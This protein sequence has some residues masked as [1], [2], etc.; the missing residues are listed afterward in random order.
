MDLKQ[1]I[2]KYS[3][4][5]GIDLIGFTSAE[6]FEELRE[7][8]EHRKN[9]GLLSSFEEEEIKKRIDPA[10]TMKKAKSIIAVGQSYYY[11]EEDN[12]HKYYG[13]LARTA[14]GKDYHI[15][16]HE[17]LEALAGYIKTI[18]KTFQYMSF[19]DTGP[20]VD[21][22]VAYRAGLGWYGFNTTLINETYGSWF[23]I[24]YMLTNLQIEPDKPVD[25]K[26]KG[27]NLC[28]ENCPGGAILKPYTI[29]PH[30][31]ISNIL[32]GK[33]DIPP[34]KR[35]ILE[36]RIYGCDECQLI[37]P[38]NKTAKPMTGKD[39]IPNELDSKLDLIKLLFI[40][41]KEFKEKF[42]ANAS[43]WRGKRVLQRNAIIALVNH[44]DSDVVHY[45]EK[46][47][48]DSRPEIKRYALWGITKLNRIRGLELAEKIY[49]TE[50]DS[51]T[52]KYIEQELL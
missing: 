34:D 15:V 1:R 9:L 42:K 14:W 13:E 3:H 24:G 4:K 8:L 40:S 27:C 46:L 17:K 10:L 18:D 37:C 51:K 49:K 38:H 32:Q 12:K 25:S 11:T 43:G 29:N 31:C 20:L 30:R 23:F 2:I 52:K 22:Q 5:I 21:R 39:F 45:L 28:I 19:V 7:V 35:S 41:N 50:T 33:E 6:P 48:K 16:L 44:G 36:K 47:L 26:C